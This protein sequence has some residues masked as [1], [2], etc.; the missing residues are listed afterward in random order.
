MKDGLD[1][2][3]IKNYAVI[4]LNTMFPVPES[5]RTYVD[6]NS[7][8]NPQYRNLLLAEY[9]FIKAIQE[10]IRKNAKTLY[11]I[12]MKDGNSTVLAKRCNDFSALESLP[13]AFNL[14]AILKAIS[15]LVTGVLY[16]CPEIFRSD[17][18]PTLTFGPDSLFKPSI[19]IIRLSLT[20]GTKSAIV[21]IAQISR[22]FSAS[23]EIVSEM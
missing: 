8:R 21:E 20:S 15:P 7:E 18:I 1:F 9:R 11:R 5:Q 22:Y 14:G 13:D 19:A 3:K 2:I 10:K 4:N 6:I 16:L 23:A 12:K 17:F